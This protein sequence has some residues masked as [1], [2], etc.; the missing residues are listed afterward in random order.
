MHVHITSW[1]E[2]CKIFCFQS[3]STIHKLTH[4]Y[5]VSP[6]RLLV[7]DS[8]STEEIEIK[9]TATKESSCQVFNKLFGA[10]SSE[11]YENNFIITL[12]L[13]ALNNPLWD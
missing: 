2:T 10:Q 6:T 13:A 11:K 3:I 12:N 8:N 5:K 7:R 4:E 1:K 9:G